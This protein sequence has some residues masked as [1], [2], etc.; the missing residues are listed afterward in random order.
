MLLFERHDDILW[1]DRYLTFMV[2]ADV[3][4]ESLKVLSRCIHK[5]IAQILAKYRPMPIRHS[6]QASVVVFFQCNH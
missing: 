5:G 4:K 3:R 6:M 2:S 1:I